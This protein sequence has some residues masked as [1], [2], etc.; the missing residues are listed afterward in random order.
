[1]TNKTELLTP[2]HCPSRPALDCMHDLEFAAQEMRVAYYLASFSQPAAWSH[3]HDAIKRFE[4]VQRTLQSHGLLESR[5]Q[6]DPDTIEADQG[7]F[8]VGA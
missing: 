4:K 8:G 7:Q 6:P 1:M 3:M 2:F 5:E